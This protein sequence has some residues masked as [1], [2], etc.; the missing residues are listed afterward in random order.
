MNE[1]NKKLVDAA[2]KTVDYLYNIDGDCPDEVYRAIAMLRQLI[3]EEFKPEKS[4]SSQFIYDIIYPAITEQVRLGKIELLAK[5][6][7]TEGWE[8]SAWV[9]CTEPEIA[10]SPNEFEK[11]RHKYPNLNH[12]KDTTLLE[13]EK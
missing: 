11:I 12:L 10:M 3:N 5:I 2:K 9:Y 7:N 1:L 8:E 13:G 6:A 4:L